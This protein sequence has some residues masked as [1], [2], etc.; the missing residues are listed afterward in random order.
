MLLCYATDNETPAI[1]MNAAV[2][3]LND[4][5]SFFI[6]VTKASSSHGYTA[7]GRISFKDSQKKRMKT[8]PPCRLPA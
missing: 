7:G 1:S 2:R 8:V 4:K 6:T 5:F 3:A